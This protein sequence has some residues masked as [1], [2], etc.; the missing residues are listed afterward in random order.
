MLIKSRKLLAMPVVG[1]AD[2]QQLGRIRSLV[3]DPKA[4]AVVALALEARGF[5]KEQRVIP[6]RAVKSIGE[7]AVTIEDAGAVARLSHVPELVP[8]VRQ[9]ANLV[10]SRV[11]S[12]DGR[13]LGTAEEYFFNPEG[14]ID[15][16]VVSGGPWRTFVQ[17]KALLPAQAVR[18]VGQASI[19]VKAEAVPQLN[20]AGGRLS[21]LQESWRKFLGYGR[22]PGG[23]QENEPPPAAQG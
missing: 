4:L 12:E 14:A 2:G 7:H 1:L 23:P 22:G 21:S 8:L 3:V 19:I 20:W 9:P 18:T 15:H 17:G 10:G 6:F 5:F 13:F 11:I 16:F